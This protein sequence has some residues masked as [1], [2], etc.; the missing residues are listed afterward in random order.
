MRRFHEALLLAVLLVAVQTAIL[1]HGH[2]DGASSGAAAQSCE[3]CAGHSAAA[4]PPAAGAPT[5]PDQQ[6][7]RVPVPQVHAVRT[8]GIRSAHRSRAPPAF[9]PV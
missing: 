1:A 7:T 9:H 6:S 3:F 4:P 8:A 5:P 2:D